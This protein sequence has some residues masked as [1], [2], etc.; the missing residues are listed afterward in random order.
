MA[1]KKLFE[2]RRLRRLR[3]WMTRRRSGR[4][5]GIR[6]RRRK[7]REFVNRPT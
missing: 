7:L 6:R 4:R 2:K 5:G 3:D 1:V